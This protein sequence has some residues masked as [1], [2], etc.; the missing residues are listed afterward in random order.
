[1]RWPLAGTLTS[2]VVLVVA[3]QL[4]VFVALPGRRPVVTRT[5][6]AEERVAE[7][8]WEAGWSNASAGD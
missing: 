5:A 6:L 8:G 4:A 3:R 7:R 2:V 1:V